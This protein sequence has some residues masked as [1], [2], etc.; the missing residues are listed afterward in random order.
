MFQTCIK[1]SISDAI[2]S[3]LICFNK[4]R[5]NEK[6][7]KH[8]SI[9]NHDADSSDYYCQYNMQHKATQRSNDTTRQDTL[10]NTLQCSTTQHNTHTTQHNTTQ[11]NT[12][13]HNT[14]QHNTTQPQA[15]HDATRY[16]TIKQLICSC[17]YDQVF[18]LAIPV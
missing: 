10:N 18:P 15:Q 12:T 8:N 3:I 13:Q 11:H 7:S 2:I 16:N 5:H 1:E 14:T 17:L 9:N 6:K 4:N